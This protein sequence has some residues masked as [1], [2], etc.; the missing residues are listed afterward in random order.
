MTAEIA[1]SRDSRSLRSK[2][3]PPTVFVVDDDISVRESLE[4]MILNAGL[5]VETFTSSR[6]F[7]LRKRSATPSC[8]VLDV[9]LPELNGFDLQE[10]IAVDAKG[11]QTVFI[12]GYGNIPMAVR[13]MKA[14][15]VEF[16][17]KP[18]GDDL[19][20]GAIQEALRRSRMALEENVENSQIRDRYTTLSV[21]E[22]DVMRLVV[23]GLMNKQVA[24][25]LGISEVTVKAH[26]GRMMRKMKT[27][28]LAELVNIVTRLPNV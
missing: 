15:A 7:L 22:R 28:S 24:A 13:A 11:L 4:F 25:E 23:R 12:S 27:K 17:T 16:L 6:E 21:R 8:L 26:R 2:P 19:L 1:F 10:H 5:R 20:L 14:G 18:L 3:V 9:N